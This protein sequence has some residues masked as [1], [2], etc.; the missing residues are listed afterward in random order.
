MKMIGDR[1]S[2]EIHVWADV[3][4]ITKAINEDELWSIKS[5]LLVILTL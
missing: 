5:I 1:G 2:D 3:L 4:E